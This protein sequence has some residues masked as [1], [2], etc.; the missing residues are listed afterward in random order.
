MIA[1]VDTI[2]TAMTTVIAAMNV[3]VVMIVNVLKKIIV[4][5]TA[6]AGKR[7]IKNMNINVGDMD[8]MKDMNVIV[9]MNNRRCIK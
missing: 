6:D 2:V 4:Q 1:A 8:I 5:T 3:L 7:K 9:I